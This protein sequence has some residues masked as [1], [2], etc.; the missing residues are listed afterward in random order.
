VLAK[1]KKGEAATRRNYR[2]QLVVERLTGVPQEGYRNKAMDWGTEHEAEA[3][4]LLSDR[5]ELWVVQTGFIAHPEMMA[6]CSPDGLVGKDAGVEI[7]C[8]FNSVVHL[9][10]L[11]CGMPP[12]HMPQVQGNLWITGRTRWHFVSYDPRMPEHLRLY[13][14]VIARD[15]D[16]IQNLTAEVA[17]FLTEVDDMHARLARR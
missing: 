1:G 6:G 4:E 5:H 15:A 7:K 10:T 3:R 16:Y 11:E 17:N 9:E 2:M 8:P 14:Q 13:H 12:E